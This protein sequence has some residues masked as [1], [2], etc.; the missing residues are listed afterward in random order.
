MKIHKYSVIDIANSLLIRLPRLLYILVH[1]FGC[2]L[3]ISIFPL[4]IFPR[5]C[6]QRL[7]TIY[8]QRRSRSAVPSS[9]RYETHGSSLAAPPTP[10]LEAPPSPSHDLVAPPTPDLAPTGHLQGRQSDQSESQGLDGLVTQLLS[11]LAHG[12]EEEQAR[13]GSRLSMAEEQNSDRPAPPKSGSLTV[14]P[15]TIKE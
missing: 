10:A 12:T 6:D 1:K 15:D 4:C 3:G 7:Q 13:P 11:P 9:K 2:H 8:A 5:Y 14:R